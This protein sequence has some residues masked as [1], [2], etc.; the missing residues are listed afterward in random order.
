[1]IDLEE[2]LKLH[3]I[4]IDKFG[5]SK[6]VRDQTLLESALNRPFAT[7]EGKDL[8]QTVEE[9]ASA[10]LESIVKNHPFHDGNKRR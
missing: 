4:A 9:K 1:M 8:Y 5:G 2:V 6:G 10:V 3:E 7:F